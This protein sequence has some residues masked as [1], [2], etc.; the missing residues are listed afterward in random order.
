MNGRARLAAW[1]VA[2][3]AVA[4]VAVPS[5]AASPSAGAGTTTARGVDDADPTAVYADVL[6][7]AV[8]RDA[9]FV[10]DL[11]WQ[12]AAVQ[13]TGYAVVAV[14]NEARASYLRVVEESQRQEALDAF[15]R[16]A[17]RTRT[18]GG[19]RASGGSTGAGGDVEAFLACTRSIESTGNYGAVSPGGTYRG[20]YQ[21]DQRTWDSNASASGRGDLVGVD[22]A[23]A[24]ASDQDQMA[25][26]LYSRRGNQPW[27]GRC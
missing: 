23:R 3:V 13:E 25:R 26:D 22:P 27:G 8:T 21:F 15:L 24:A 11:G 5:V 7:A 4:C 16:A 20:A 19:S 18:S 10:Y 14:Q 12:A 1:V 17:A 9:Q 6:S 2:G